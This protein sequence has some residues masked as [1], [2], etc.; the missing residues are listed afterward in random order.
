MR[1]AFVNSTKIWSG[2]KTW[3]LEFGDELRRL[4]DE[5][6][7]FASDARFI[8]AVRAAGHQAVLLRF[9][10]DYHPGTIARFWREFR[11]RGIQVACLNIQKELRSAGI[12]ARLSG[13]PVVHRVGLA[14]D[15][16]GKWD[17]RLAYRTVVSRVLVPSATLRQELLSAHAFLAPGRVFAIPNGKHVSG[18]VRACKGAP[19]RF[20]MA[21]RLE[22]T[23]RHAD[24]L[25]AL[26]ALARD[27]AL[28]AFL[29]DIHGDGSEEA[30]L[31]RQIEAL[32]LGA[33]VRMLGFTRNLPES[34]ANCDFGVLASEQEGMPNTA[35]EF[36]AAGLPVVATDTGGTAEAVRPAINGWL[37]RPGD[38]NALRA[39]LRACLTLPDGEYARMSAGAIALMRDEFDPARLAVRLHHFFAETERK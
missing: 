5:P 7:Y 20:A 37:F 9:G 2:V 17:Q 18:R 28:P 16:T 23:K 27:P 30:A 39:H 32:G 26:G 1:I 31:H 29:L 19:V 14:G 33:R 6:H 4:G 21:S 24:V 34:L 10:F 13:I 22:R 15:L 11:R 25:D 38:G 3:M 12:A 8:E 35:L 36:L